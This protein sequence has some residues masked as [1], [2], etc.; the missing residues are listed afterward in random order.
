MIADVR[1]HP[2]PLMR[3]DTN[4]SKIGNGAIYWILSVPCFA[5][6][7]IALSWEVLPHSAL[8]FG[9]TGFDLFNVWIILAGPLALLLL[10]GLHRTFISLPARVLLA[11]VSAAT[12]L[13]SVALL[14]VSLGL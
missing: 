5:S 7:L 13:L 3:A 2:D 8:S 12:V 1:R 11:L 14:L 6:V 4:P 10:R 9:R